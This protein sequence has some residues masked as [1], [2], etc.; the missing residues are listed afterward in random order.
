MTRYQY[1]RGNIFFGEDNSIERVELDEPATCPYCKKP[2][3]VIYNRML[4][5]WEC[6]KQGRALYYTDEGGYFHRCTHIEKNPI[7]C[8]DCI[9]EYERDKP[10]WGYAYGLDYEPEIDEEDADGELD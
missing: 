3:N 5:I 1:W 7:G 6:D 8:P 4:E 10:G 2:T 9:E